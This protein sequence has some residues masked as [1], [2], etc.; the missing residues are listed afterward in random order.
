MDYREQ[1][2]QAIEHKKNT[3]I[4]LSDQ[5]FDF[6]ELGFKEVRSAELFCKKLREEGFQVTMPI[7]G[8]PTAFKAEYGSGH[9]VIGLTAEYDALPGLGQKAGCTVKTE[10][11]NPDGH[12]CGHNLLGAGV[13]AAALAIKSYLMEHPESGTVV[14]F[15]CPSE[16]KGNSK[17]IMARDGVFDGLDCAFTWH[18]GDSNSVWCSSTL[19]NISVYFDF[20]GIT[21]HA[22]ASPE[23]GR[24]ALDA[25]ELMSVGVNY[26]REHVIQEARIHYA[27]INVG[28][29][30]PNVVQG[31]SRV[32][33]FIR[34]PKT[35]Q[36]LDIFERIK[37]I[38]RGAA[39]MTGT[40]SSYEIYS[41]L[42]DYMPNRVLS[43]VLYEEMEATGAP[44][45]SQEDFDRAA[46]F[47]YH[48]YPEETVKKKEALIHQTYGQKKAEILLEKPL[49]TEILPINWYVPVM[50]GSTDVGDLSHVVP[51]AQL[52]YA[53]MAVGTA[54][55]TWQATAQ[56]K[57]S[58]AHKAVL[59][60]GSAMA[61][62]AVRVM[63][64]ENL[65]REARQS[66]K[67]ET[68]GVYLSPIG[69]EI[70]PRLDD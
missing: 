3:I 32:H 63:Q 54:L 28:G 62:A 29:N 18:P 61:M 53:T 48:S 34:A 10:V 41:G 42:S 37:D 12:G 5:V 50:S 57:L 49:S 68:G 60:A 7:I 25:A 38:A 43:E 55:H 36:V 2:C 44:S 26:L 14:L 59:A 13:F 16:E 21:A 11:E 17:T 66:F 15:G 58:A 23:L 8:I 4:D 65:L 27:Y 1:I 64:D 52:T 30:A 51:T 19:A 46:E 47:F 6:A 20:Q 33:Y 9:P 56:G 40:E 24:S 39:L 70:K 45:Y 31:S 69:K 22:A 67:Q 35:S